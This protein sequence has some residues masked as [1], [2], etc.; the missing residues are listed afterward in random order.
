MRYRDDELGLCRDAK[1]VYAME[2]V[3]DAIVM[4]KENAKL[5]GVTNLHFETGAAEK[6]MPRWKEEGIQSDVIV[7]DP[8]AQRARP[9]LY[10]S[11]M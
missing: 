10:R 1:K 2:I 7:V 6:I 5:N 3:D 11:S 8:P 9:C 4:A